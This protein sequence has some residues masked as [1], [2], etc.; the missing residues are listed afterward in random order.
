MKISSSSTFVKF[1][2]NLTQKMLKIKI[3]NCKVT[4]DIFESDSIFAA[5]HTPPEH[6]YTVCGPQRIDVESRVEKVEKSEFTLKGE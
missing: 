4:N 2:F 6:K 1:E 5:L 3:C